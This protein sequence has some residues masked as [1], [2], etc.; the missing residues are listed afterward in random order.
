MTN[1]CY[2]YIAGMCTTTTKPSKATTTGTSTTTIFSRVS[3]D[4]G[5][6]PQ[7][8]CLEQTVRTLTLL[9]RQLAS[10]VALGAFWRSRQRLNSMPTHSQSPVSSKVTALDTPFQV[11]VGSTKLAVVAFLTSL[12]FK[13]SPTLL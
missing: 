5:S 1:I 11:F 6:Q 7:V 10:H 12:S 3:C 9:S 2:S 4:R 8:A 13:Y